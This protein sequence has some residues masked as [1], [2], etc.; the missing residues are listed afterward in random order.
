MNDE[1]PKTSG[2]HAAM[3]ENVIG[4]DRNRLRK[5]QVDSLPD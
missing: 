5:G 2:V 3:T 1:T 4:V